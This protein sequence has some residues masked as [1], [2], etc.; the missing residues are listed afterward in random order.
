[1]KHHKKIQ[2]VLVPMLIFIISFLL[3][4]KEPVKPASSYNDFTVFTEDELDADRR[5]L[6]YR[7]KI[8]EFWSTNKLCLFPW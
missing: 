5:Q 8:E 3:I 7:S 4:A 1:M 2:L 6:T